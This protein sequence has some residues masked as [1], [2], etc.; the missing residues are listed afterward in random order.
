MMNIN[1][2]L[3]YYTNLSHCF[4]KFFLTFAAAKKRKR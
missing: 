1:A 4:W 3:M 2:L